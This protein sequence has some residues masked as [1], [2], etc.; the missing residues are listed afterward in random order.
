MS[1]AGRT[2]RDDPAAS[3]RGPSQ[4]RTSGLANER[5]LRDRDATLGPK[6]HQILSAGKDPPPGA[7]TGGGL[8]ELSIDDTA[9]TEADSDVTL[10]GSNIKEN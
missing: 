7:G 2:S 1:A 3:Q 10:K 9:G 4:R 5:W 6:S 8:N